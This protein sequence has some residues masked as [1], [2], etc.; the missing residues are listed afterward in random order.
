[1]IPVNFH[2]PIRTQIGGPTPN[3]IKSA[4]WPGVLITYS[5]FVK[6]KKNGKSTEYQ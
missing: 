1:M 5:F 4:A 3:K 6:A 2:I